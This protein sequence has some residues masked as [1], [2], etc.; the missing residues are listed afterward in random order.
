LELGGLGLSNEEISAAV[1]VTAE[2]LPPEASGTERPATKRRLQPAREVVLTILDEVGLPM[3]SRDIQAYARA[4]YGISIDPTR[5]GSLRRTEMEAYD[6]RSQRSVW[7][8]YGLTDRGEAVKRLLARSD[9]PIQDRVV[10]PFSG[11]RLFYETTERLCEM[12]LTERARIMDFDAFRIFVADH[13]RDLPGVKNFQKGE[14]PFN[15]WLAL[16][17]NAVLEVAERDLQDRRHIA[18]RLTMLGEKQRLFG[19]E[20]PAEDHSIEPPIT[21]EKLAR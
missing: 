12:A 14:F 17:K 3:L 21:F 2:R 15:D 6:R 10:G 4:K 8:A 1:A 7:L 19:T 18:M 5:F 11:R 16:A 9:K 13:A 20:I